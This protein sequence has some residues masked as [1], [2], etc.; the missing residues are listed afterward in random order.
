[1][2]LFYGD[3]PTFVIKHFI[4]RDKSVRITRFTPF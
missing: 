1:M 3:S 2:N 4:E